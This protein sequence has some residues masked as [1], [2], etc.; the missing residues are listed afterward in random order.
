MLTTVFSVVFTWLWN[1]TDG[2]VL[3]AAVLHATMNASENA[4]KAVLPELRGSGLA[5]ISFGV[6]ALVGALVLW[7][8][9]ALEPAAQPRP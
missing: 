8:R 1:R 4:L 5:S 9:R 7:Y 3:L 2:S 6:I